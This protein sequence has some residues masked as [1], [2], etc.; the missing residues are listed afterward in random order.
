[1][2][3]ERSGAR[4]RALAG[5]GV[6]SAVLFGCDHATKAAATSSLAGSAPVP[7]L[8]ERVVLRYV[9]NDDVAFSLAARIGLGP[10]PGLLAAFAAIALV[11]LGIVWWRARQRA[12]SIGVV[13]V[14]FAAVFAGALGNLVDRVMHGHVVDFIHVEH[15]PVFNAADIFVVAGITL[16]AF[17][18]RRGARCGT[19]RRSGLDLG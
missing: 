14:G 3:L 8:G 18:K 16:V 9:E 19:R 1:M 2:Q 13:D 6:F 10:S 11:V 4:G 7:I 17:A 5:V 12:S 15:W